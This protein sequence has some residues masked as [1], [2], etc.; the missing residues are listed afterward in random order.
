MRKPGHALLLA[1]AVL[2]LSACGSRKALK[3]KPGMDP[4]PVAYGADRAATPAEMMEHDMQARPD[5]SAEPLKQSQER[6][7]D[8]FDL[9]PS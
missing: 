8:P 3:A 7:D 5:R 2:A 6:P 9:P 4:A 1:C